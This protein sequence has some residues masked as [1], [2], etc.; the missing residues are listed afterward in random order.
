MTD[1]CGSAWLRE[2]QGTCLESRCPIRGLFD[3]DSAN[4]SDFEMLSSL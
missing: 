1:A 3:L 2:S 4:I